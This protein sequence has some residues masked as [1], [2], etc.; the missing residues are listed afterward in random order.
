MHTHTHTVPSCSFFDALPRQRIFIRFRT[1][2]ECVFVTMV[3]YSPPSDARTKLAVV[4]G[5]GQCRTDE[6]SI[7][8]NGTQVDRCNVNEYDT[9][10][11]HPSDYRETYGAFRNTFIAGKRRVHTSLES[12]TTTATMA[13]R[14][15][16]PFTGHECAYSA[17]P[18]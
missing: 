13:G 1:A 6:K 3:T 9:N 7:A 10:V 4:A 18:T 11:A 12:R 8:A 2:S 15:C 17:R 5:G 14:F 16:V